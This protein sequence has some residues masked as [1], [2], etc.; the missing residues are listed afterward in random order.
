MQNLS[1]SGLLRSPDGAAAGGCSRLDLSTD[2]RLETYFLGDTIGRGV[3]HDSFGRLVTEATAEMSGR[4]EGNLFLLDEVFRYTDGRTQTR[5]WSI[6][7]NADRS[8]EITAPD[9]LGKGSGA[10]NGNRLGLD[11]RLRVPVGSRELAL[12]FDDRMY[13]LDDGVLINT[14]SARKFGIPVARLA[15]SFQR[16]G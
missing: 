8:Y 2:L 13:L 6:R 4:W 9:M 5:T 16:A 14:S 7:I 10:A 11:Y 3:I 1:N 12:R 15:F